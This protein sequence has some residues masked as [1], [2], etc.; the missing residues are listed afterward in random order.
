MKSNPLKDL[1][2]EIQYVTKKTQQD[3]ADDLGMNRTYL[4]DQVNKGEN[5]TL[6]NK[7]SKYLAEIRQNVGEEKTPPIKSSHLEEI[8]R[9]LEI[10]DEKIKNQEEIIKRQDAAITRLSGIIEFLQ[11]QA[12]TSSTAMLRICEQNGELLRNLLESKSHS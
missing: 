1:L 4:T 3:V 6:K 8:S 2:K 10:R 5:I 9:E 12:T 11:V 7:L